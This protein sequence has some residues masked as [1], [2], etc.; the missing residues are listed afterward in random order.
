MHVRVHV[1]LAG[2][3]QPRQATQ[4]Q[5][6]RGGERQAG[7]TRAVLLKRLCAHR[8]HRPLYEVIRPTRLEPARALDH[9]AA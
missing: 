5:K 8:P 1:Q 4:A 6:G 7:L 3:E 2:G 9:A